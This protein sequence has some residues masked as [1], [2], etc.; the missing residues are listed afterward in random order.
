[1]VAGAASATAFVVVFFGVAYALG[2]EELSVVLAAVR[3]RR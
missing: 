2:S 1:L 3:R